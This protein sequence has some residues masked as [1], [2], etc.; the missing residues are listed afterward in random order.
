MGWHGLI[1]LKSN[2]ICLNCPPHAASVQV[3]GKLAVP[4][5]SDVIMAQLIQRDVAE[6]SHEQRVRLS[7]H[8]LEFAT[9]CVW[10]LAQV[11]AIQDK[12]A[13]PNR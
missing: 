13:T 11:N 1:Y 4:K 3:T 10:D 6:L 12:T 9:V 7:R 2:S 5:F 8:V